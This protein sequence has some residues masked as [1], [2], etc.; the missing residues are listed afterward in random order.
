MTRLSR[1]D[2]ALLNAA[3]RDLRDAAKV[4][5]HCRADSLRSGGHSAPN[6][7]ACAHVAVLASTLA[8]T[9][10]ITT[11]SQIRSISAY[12]AET[13]SAERDPR[14][15]ELLDPARQTVPVAH[16]KSMELQVRESTAETPELEL[17]L[18]RI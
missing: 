8:T 13:R 17:I 1:S 14:L 7:V 15:L 4:L 16:D 10:G 6:T 18:E 2:R 5:G 3:R 9:S 11:I 12:E